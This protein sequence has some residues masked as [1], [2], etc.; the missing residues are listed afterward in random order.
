MSCYLLDVNLLIA[1]FDPQ[2]VLHNK[3]HSW[4]SSVQNEKW[5]SCSIIQNAFIR[6]I[7]SPSYPSIDF[8]PNQL[9]NYLNE[10]IN[11]S[12]Y[13]FLSENISLL[14]SK[15]FDHDFIQGHKQ[16]TD[17]Y[18]LGLAAYN[19]IKLATLDTKIPLKAVRLATKEN[20][21]VIN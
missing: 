20:L 17:I 6:I 16:I 21:F 14:D 8:L 7:S 10:F 19:K 18:L 12:K 15:I 3:A 11:K 4:F 2:H 13:V 1:L 9:I 5:A